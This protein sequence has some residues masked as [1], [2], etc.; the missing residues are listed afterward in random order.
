[1]SLDRTSEFS[2]VLFFLGKF[3]GEERLPRSSKLFVTIK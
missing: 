2:A 3:T 1:M